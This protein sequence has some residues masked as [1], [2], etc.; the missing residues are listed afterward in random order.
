MT[1]AAD[2]APHLLQPRHTKWFS[3][4]LPSLNFC[5]I[6]HSPITKEPALL[7]HQPPGAP[8]PR[9]QLRFIA[10]LFVGLLAYS[11]MSS[12]EAKE[13]RFT[14]EEGGF[15]AP[16]STFTMVIDTEA[17]TVNGERV[18]AMETSEHLI[19]TLKDRNDLRRPEDGPDTTVA[20]VSTVRLKEG[21][22]SRTV[23]AGKNGQEPEV[24]SGKKLYP[25]AQQHAEAERRTETETNRTV[26][27]FNPQGQL[28]VYCDATWST[29]NGGDGIRAIGK[30]IK[31]L[32]DDLR[33]TRDIVLKLS[34]DHSNKGVLNAG[35]RRSLLT[36]VDKTK[37]V[38]TE[39]L[40]TLRVLEHYAAKTSHS[41]KHTGNDCLSILKPYST[42][43]S[44]FGYL[45]SKNICPDMVEI[46]QRLA[47]LYQRD[48]RAR[49]TNSRPRNYSGA[50]NDNNVNHLYM[51]GPRKD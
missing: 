27:E 14:C 1:A 29:K 7:C 40:V 47:D 11:V 39:E 34:L 46:T 8:S 4:D 24:V 22:L 15:G 16:S 5:Q 44:T 20:E 38:V 12:A 19:R 2:H 10:S 31:Q 37:N 43:R 26:L 3:A 13:I 51:L 36:T 9:K 21:S 45:I 23:Y 41:N 18:S 25:C 32:D 6:A 33:T 50:E 17:K 48:E 42:C 49:K 35:T 30:T 28:H